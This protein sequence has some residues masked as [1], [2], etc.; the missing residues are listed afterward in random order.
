MCPQILQFGFAPKVLMPAEL[1]QQAQ[2]RR[3]WGQNV[4]ATVVAAV[5]PCEQIRCLKRNEVAITL[6]C[7]FRAPHK[8]QV[9]EC[10]IGKVG[11]APYVPP[12]A[13]LSSDLALI[14]E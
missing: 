3:S 11:L 12:F 13:C 2:S 10:S 4:F 7:W 14:I 9:G 5:L 1:V 6:E 8:R